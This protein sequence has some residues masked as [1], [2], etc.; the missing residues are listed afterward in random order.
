LDNT[1][2][3]NPAIHYVVFMAS[4][5]PLIITW[6]TGKGGSLGNSHNPEQGEV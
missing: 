2:S 4:S 1:L 3:V 5:Q 6:L